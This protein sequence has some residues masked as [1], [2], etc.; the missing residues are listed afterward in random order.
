VLLMSDGST[1]VVSYLHD[2]TYITAATEAIK[3]NFAVSV[4][5]GVPEYR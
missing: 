3:N 5:D 2:S 1:R 4:S